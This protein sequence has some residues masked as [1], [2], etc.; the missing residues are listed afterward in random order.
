MDAGELEAVGLLGVEPLVARVE[1]REVR[2]V[3]GQRRAQLG[4]DVVEALAD[5][6][7]LEQRRDDRQQVA[8]RVVAHEV[9]DA[10]RDVG[11]D[12]RVA[13]AVAADPRPERQRPGVGGQRDAD[14]LERERQVVEHLRHRAVR[15][16]VEVVEGVAGLVEHLRAVQAQLVGLPEQVDELGGAARH[17]RVV[18]ADAVAL[19]RVE[20]VGDGAQLEQHRAPRGLGR[21]RGEDRPRRQ[22][23]DRRLDLVLRGLAA[24]ERGLDASRRGVERVAGGTPGAALDARAVHLLGHVGQVEVRRERPREPDR[25]GQ[26]DGVEQVRRRAEIDPCGPAYL[27][28]ELEQ[29]GGVLADEGAAEE[30][31][32]RAD[33]A[34]QGGVVVRVVE[35]DER[36]VGHG[37]RPVRDE[38]DGAASLAHRGQP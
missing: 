27:L 1:V 19:G 38:R 26:V 17:A 28:D 2:E 5:R 36:G 25:G 37:V 33:V 14:R 7:L 24:R 18:E 34:A 20:Q 29:L 10:A 4:R 13:V 12:E 31:A 3:G 35:L 23:R 8:H 30:V 21:V 15:E 16:V 11:R 22:A 9:D 32:E 6:D